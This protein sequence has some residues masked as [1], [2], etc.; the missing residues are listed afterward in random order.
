[1]FT[2]RS[3]LVVASAGAVALGLGFAV[4]GA[5]AN[6]IGINYTGAGSFGQTQAQATGGYS[7]AP[8][9]SAGVVAQDNWNNTTISYTDGNGYG[10]SGSLSTIVDSNGA[11]VTGMSVTTAVNT[12]DSA[13][14]G[15]PLKLYPSA[16]TAGWGFSGNNLTMLEGG[17]YPSPKVT[18][19]GIPYSSYDV[20]VYMEAAG[21]NGGSGAVMINANSGSGS[22]DSTNEYFYDYGWPNG[23]FIQATATSSAANTAVSNYVLFTGNTASDITLTAEASGWNT[24]LAAFQIVNTGTSTIPEPATLGLMAVLGVGILLLKRRKPKQA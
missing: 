22:V 17:V 9:A 15:D 1:M 4:A 23:A 6:S 2:L 16:G 21:G 24:G 18:I 20:Y 12:S 14:T 8:T 13:Y 7:L 10:N 5:R 3:S 11:A 19:T